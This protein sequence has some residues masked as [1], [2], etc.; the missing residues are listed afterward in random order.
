MNSVYKFLLCYLRRYIK[1]DKII[2]PL[3]GFIAG[4]FSL[5][6]VQKRRQFLTC[7][8]LSRFCDTFVKMGVEKQFLPEVKNFEVHIWFLCAIMQQYICSYETDCLNRGVNSFL[9]K[10][11][12]YNNNDV[13]MQSAFNKSITDLYPR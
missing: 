9:M 7:L 11:A 3:A 4:L 5:I 13:M 1:S 2:A 12:A 8:L 10:W 6:D